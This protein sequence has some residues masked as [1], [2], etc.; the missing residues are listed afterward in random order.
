M[1]DKEDHFDADAWLASFWSGE[2]MVAEQAPAYG[3]G[4]RPKNPVVTET[5]ALASSVMD[6]VERLEKINATFADQI[7]RSGTAVGSHTR[8]AQGAESMADFLQKMK[9]AHK[10]LEETDYRLD[11]CHLKAHYP[12]D[13]DLVRRTKVLFPLFNAILS[14]TRKRINDARKR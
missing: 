10:E 5:F 6:Y 9:I 8:E 13:H 1:N 2:M 3:S 12:H 11:L 14:T 7:L 4:N